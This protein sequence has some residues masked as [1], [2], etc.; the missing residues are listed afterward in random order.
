[1]CIDL[2]DLNKCCP[3]AKPWKQKLHKMLDEKIVVIKVEVQ[4]LLDAGFI[5]KVQYLIW[6][7]NV[8][9]AKKKNDKWRICTDFTDLNKWCPKYDF[10]LSRIDKVVDWAVG[11]EMMVLL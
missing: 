4:R 9:M 3:S 1:M 11:Y 10:P 7:A 5:R 8:V 6:L 2:T